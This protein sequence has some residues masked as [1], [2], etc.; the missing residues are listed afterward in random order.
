MNQVSREGR[1][2]SL[3]EK[4]PS[5]ET[6]LSFLRNSVLTRERVNSLLQERSQLAS[7]IS[8]VFNIAA[9]FLRNMNSRESVEVQWVWSMGVAF[10][11]VLLDSCFSI[12]TASSFT[13]EKVP[14][15]S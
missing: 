7:D 12:F 2:L 8:D 13:S 11:V 1:P 14:S 6:V 5:F 3:A 4:H 9:E 10:I 15:V